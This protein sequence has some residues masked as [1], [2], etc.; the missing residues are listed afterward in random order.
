M[1]IKGLWNLNLIPADNFGD[2]RLWAVQTRGMA[3]ITVD[4]VVDITRDLRVL[5]VI[6]IVASVASRAL[7]ARIVV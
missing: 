5:E 3:L 4:A 2:H 7:K 6:R 1:G